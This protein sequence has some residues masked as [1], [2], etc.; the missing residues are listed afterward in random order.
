MHNLLSTIKFICCTR[1]KLM[2]EPWGH[3]IPCHPPPPKR[4][5]AWKGQS[6]HKTC[7]SF[8]FAPLSLP[9]NPWDQK[10]KIFFLPFW[11]DFLSHKTM[12]SVLPGQFLEVLKEEIKKFRKS[13]L[14]GLAFKTVICLHIGLEYLPFS[15]LFCHYS[16]EFPSK[17][18]KQPY[19][20][21]Q[22]T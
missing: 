10:G 19:K 17:T 6:S 12:W 9:I 5:L 18:M 1:S 15:L 4:T 11:L 20:E 16:P 3:P 21:M 22:K 2:W 8:L 7:C 13:S 14:R